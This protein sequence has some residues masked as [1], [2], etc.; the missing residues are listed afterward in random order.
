VVTGAAAARYGHPAPRRS[1]TLALPR[2]GTLVLGPRTLLMGVVNVTPDSFSDGGAH[3]DPAAALEHAARLVEDGADLLDVGGESTRPGAAEV[4]ADEQLRRVLPVVAGIARAFPRVPVSIDTRGAR[5]AREVLAAGASIVNDVS[6]LRHDP[7]MR[8]AVAESGAPAIVMHMRGT[9]ADM[10]SR[11]DYAEVVHDV[12]AE[13]GAALDAARAAGVRGVI[14]DPGI[15]FAK[16]AAQSLALVAALPRF[17]A[18]GAPLLVGPSRKSFL[19]EFCGQGDA[20]AAVPP[21]VSRLPATVAAAA[22]CAWLGAHVVRVHDVAACRAAVG[23][24]DA[25][26]GA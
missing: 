22:L 10:R 7:G 20:A 12:L 2:G 1:F 24:A 23:F 14:A 19:A 8:A 4:S 9:P 18:L 11:T 25:L 16:T 26:R 15:G 3:A 6:G 21:A 5:V 13:L 17:A